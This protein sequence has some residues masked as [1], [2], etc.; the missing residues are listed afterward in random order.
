MAASIRKTGI[1]VR[2][3]EDDIAKQVGYSDG[4]YFSQVL[5]KEKEFSQHNTVVTILS[6]DDVGDNNC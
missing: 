5:K 3:S 6:S 2:D 1:A 4:N